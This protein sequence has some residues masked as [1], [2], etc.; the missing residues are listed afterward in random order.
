MQDK[1]IRKISS[2]QMGLD[3]ATLRKEVDNAD[4]ATVAVM[5]IIGNVSDF[6]KDDFGGKGEWVRLKGIFR[7]INILTDEKFRSTR[8][9][10]PGGADELVMAQLQIAKEDNPSA[11]LQVAFDFHVKASET[12]TGYSF[13][14]ENILPEEKSIDPLENLME[15]VPALPAKA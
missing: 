2:G 7:G 14:Y 3:S 15:I 9:F 5:R 4:G 12:G 13:E 1:I 6:D 10:L 8:A 11:V